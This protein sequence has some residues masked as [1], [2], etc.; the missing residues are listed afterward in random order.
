MLFTHTS[1]P[2]PFHRQRDCAEVLLDLALQQIGAALVQHVAVSV[3][4]GGEEDRLDQAGPVFKGQEFHQLLL[5]RTHNFAG[6]QPTRHLHRF[7]HVLMHVLRCDQV[8]SF[9]SVAVQLQRVP[10][11]QKAEGLQLLLEQG[12]SIVGGNLRRF[13][14][15]FLLVCPQEQE[16]CTSVG[17]LTATSVQRGDPDLSGYRKLRL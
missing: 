13:G 17:F 16:F 4:D 12:L 6:D 3:I 10:A 5:F 14:Y 2:P 11:D 8:Q 9:Q 7:A 15:I 1:P